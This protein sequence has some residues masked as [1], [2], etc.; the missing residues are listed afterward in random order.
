MGIAG[1]TTRLKITNQIDSTLLLLLVDTP[2]MGEQDT[3]LD[4]KNGRNC[5]EPCSNTSYVFNDYS[6]DNITLSL[7][8]EKQ[9]HTVGDKLDK[10]VQ[11][12]NIKSSYPYYPIKYFPP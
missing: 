7:K 1:E 11:K 6:T 8:E 4:N 9:L 10:N 12:G 3:I 5:I 2:M